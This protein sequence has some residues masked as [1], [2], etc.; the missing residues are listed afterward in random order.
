M[1]IWE[2]SSDHELNDYKI[3]K[4]HQ[5]KSGIIL[6]GS[7]AFVFTPI[8]NNDIR[9]YLKILLRGATNLPDGITTS[10]ATNLLLSYI[11]CN[12]K[13]TI[14]PSIPTIQKDLEYI[15]GLSQKNFLH[16]IPTYLTLMNRVYVLLFMLHYQMPL[17]RKNPPG[18]RN[19]S[20]SVYCFK[21]KG[22]FSSLS[23]KEQE[24]ISMDN[25]FVSSNSIP[26]DMINGVTRNDITEFPKIM[27]TDVQNSSMF[28]DDT[29]D[30]MV[31]Q[32]QI[33]IYRFQYSNK[34][35]DHPNYP[36][37][38]K[39]P[40]SSIST[41]SNE[42]G[43]LQEVPTI[44]SLLSQVNSSVKPQISIHFDTHSQPWNYLF[45][46]ILRY[47]DLVD[48][49]PTT[50]LPDC[51][52][53]GDTCGHI[54]H[55]TLEGCASKTL[56]LTMLEGLKN[57][58][59]KLPSN[60]VSSFINYVSFHNPIWDL[61]LQFMYAKKNSQRV[62][63]QSK[64]SMEKYSTNCVCPCSSLFS[65]LHRDKNLYQL[66]N[67]VECEKKVYT[68][69][70]S[71]IG[72]LHSEK[73]D[74][75]HRI[76]MRIVQGRYSSLI[77]KFKVTPSSENKRNG[78]VVNSFGDVHKGIVKLPPYVKSNS[79]YDVFNFD[80]YVLMNVIIKL[81]LMRRI[82]TFCP[83]FDLKA[84]NTHCSFTDKHSGTYE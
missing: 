35:G 40:V 74:F 23:R 5:I 75:Y 52:Q 19:R 8:E 64:E 17:Q 55:S 11:R 41:Q 45:H 4:F 67:F 78:K 54:L 58:G 21:N 49:F 7:E 53:E 47:C 32:Q 50:S 82:L 69:P 68:N 73:D 65:N 84:R 18:N 36:L 28:R 80:R 2:L 61:G 15:S 62:Y 33:I 56:Y 27:Y 1:L 83:Y 6:Y 42:N 9:S 26:D 63:M 29:I 44:Q 77:S 48:H 31:F 14:I 20:S 24:I 12:S 25:V 30:S 70:I 39:R 3:C 22:W 79:V 72:H 81:F 51:Y 10:K 37:T 34:K 66:P 13:R 76:I 46:H 60:V 16:D 43:S 57:E 71:F 38:L 59:P